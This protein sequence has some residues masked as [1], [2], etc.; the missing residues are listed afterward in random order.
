MRVFSVR[1]KALLGRGVFALFSTH[2][3]AQRFL[4]QSAGIVRQC[5]E[6]VE[7]TII[8]GQGTSSTVFAAYTYD[9]LHDS[10]IFDGLYRDAAVAAD[11]A[12]HKGHVVEF[13][14]DAP[15]NP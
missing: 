13:L 12:G 14:I 1:D 8:G 3:M 6:V 9:D 5:G 4:D 10:H 2:E 11:A 7:L 15:H